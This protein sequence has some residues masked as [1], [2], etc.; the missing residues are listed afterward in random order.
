MG[1]KGREIET[2]LKRQKGKGEKSEREREK[3][4]ESGGEIKNERG[5]E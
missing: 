4:K 5:R 1:K 3:V 2:G